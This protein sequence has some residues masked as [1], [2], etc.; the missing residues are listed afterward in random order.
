MKAIRSFIAIELPYEIQEQLQQVVQQLKFSLPDIV[1]WVAPKNIHLT[2]RFL[3]DVSPANM[4]VLKE[5]LKLI[6]GKH[7]SF[8]VCPGG[9][10]AFPTRRRPRVLWVGVESSPILKVL[11]QAIEIEVQKL[12]C[13]PESRPFSP[14]LTLGRV[15]QNA[16]FEAINRVA[17]GLTNLQQ[18]H[19]VDSFTVHQLTLFRSDLKPGGAV[20]T[21]ITTVS[22]NQNHEV[23]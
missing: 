1:H 16:S 19:P 15:K 6:A 5:A 12:G 13:A 17:A 23:K 21:P 7:P 11:Q 9:I 10:N 4:D 22:L 20:Y 14:H 18:A 3:G 8:E 2:L